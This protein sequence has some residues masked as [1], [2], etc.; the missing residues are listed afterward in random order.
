MSSEIKTLTHNQ[1]I[2]V[3]CFRYASKIQVMTLQGCFQN[4]VIRY[5][6]K[7]TWEA[8]KEQNKRNGGPEVWSYQSP[9]V[10]TADYA[11][12]A[13]A[14]AKA[15]AEMEA[16]PEIANGDWVRIEG[17]EYQVKVIGER[18]S[19]PVKFIPREI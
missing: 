17:L 3:T 8:Y 15:A 14:L 11:G 2:K 18:Y 10:L 4:D 13:E 5:G 9:A 16:A 6:E 7:K 12:K 19:N 1:E